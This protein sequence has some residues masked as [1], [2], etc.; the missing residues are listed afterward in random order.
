MNF[1]YTKMHLME[2]LRANLSL[3]K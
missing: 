3:S 1:G 2:K